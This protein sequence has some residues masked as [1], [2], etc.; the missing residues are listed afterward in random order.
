MP[1]FAGLCP[2]AGGWLVARAD[3][4]RG[5]R[6]IELR[7]RRS[8]QTPGRVAAVRALGGKAKAG[9]KGGARP[10]LCFA[11][12]NGGRALEAPR[13]T[14]LG[15][16]ERLALLDRA[17]PGL[18]VPPPPPGAS[19]ADVLDALVCLWTAER[20]AAGRVRTLP[21]GV[22]VPEPDRFKLVR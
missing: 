3:V 13:R 22:V 20:L 21:D 19:A 11:A 16:R 4:R 10:E 1:R 2:C 7:V 9:P 17:Y 18:P 12:L 8:A 5:R 6:A 14:A 15:R